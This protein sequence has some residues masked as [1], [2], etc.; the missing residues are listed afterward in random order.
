MN[1][2]KFSG[3][4]FDVLDI[5]DSQFIRLKNRQREKNPSALVWLPGTRHH[6]Y[7]W[8]KVLHERRHGL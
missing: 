3:T 6:R 8:I 7:W 1:I 2:S 4:V 5:I